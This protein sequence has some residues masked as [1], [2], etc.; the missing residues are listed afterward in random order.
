[1]KKII[2]ITG[3]SQGLGR[4]MTE[5]FSEL[6]HTVLGCARDQHAIDQLQQELGKP[7]RFEVVDVTDEEGVALWSKK[8][9][10]RYGIPDMLV[11]NAG[12]IHKP[13]PLWKINSK[14]FDKTIDVNIKGVANVIR[15]FVPAMV[16]ENRGVIINVSSGLGRYAKPNTGPYCATKWAIEGLTKALSLE[17]PHG[18]A[19]VTLW[20]GAI[21]T[22]A[23]EIF[24][25]SENAD[26][27]IRPEAWASIAV[28]YMLHIGPSDNGKPLATPT[29]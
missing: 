28:P 24:Y 14:V 9:I 21:R 20:P 23:L 5:K 6:G 13:L 3:V 25:G 22:K 12:Y 7:H 15:H 18:M 10:T 26:Q 19:A 1:M 27:Y 4:A 8:M 11:N 17:L 16:E 29:G 2:V